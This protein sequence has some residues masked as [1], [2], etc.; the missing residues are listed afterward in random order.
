M[1][2]RVVLWGTAVMVT[3]LALALLWQVRVVVVYVLLSLALAAA[4]RPLFKRPAGQSSLARLGLNMLYLVALGSLLFLL[5]AGI[6]AALRDIQEL[7]LQVSAQ[8]AWRQPAWLQGS[9]LQDLL[10]T[11]LPPPSQLFAAMIGEEGEFVLPAVLGLTQGIF[12]LLSAALVVLFLS[13]YWGLDQNHFERLWLSLLPP[14]QRSQMRDIWQTVEVDLGGYIRRQ[15]GQALLAALLLGLGYWLLGSPYPALLALLGALALL[16]PIVGP[17]LVVISPLLLGLLSGVGLSLA[18]AVYTLLVIAA[19]TWLIKWRLAQRA[20]VNPILTIV[21]L[22]A[23]ADAYG[24][25]GILFAPPLSAACHILWN[26]LISHRAF[27]GESLRIS[28]LKE[29][30]A[31][32]RLAIAAMDESPSLLVASS[33]ERLAALLEKAEPVLN[34]ESGSR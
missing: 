2:R 26:R 28:D 29:R 30:Q 6:G 15:A 21:I 14:G 16:I 1:T 22:L 17:F 23:L 27:A 33:L 10:D 11:R 5:A 31:E 24:L 8:D 32:V 3:L 18:T 13:L 9:A 4:A 20:Q 19:L 25:L 34:S 12:S 7:A